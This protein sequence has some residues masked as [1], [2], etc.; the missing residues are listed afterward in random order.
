MAMTNQAAP[1]LTVFFDGACPLC[2]AEIGL[3]QKCAGAERVAFVDVSAAPDAPVAPG[4]SRGDAMKRF[5]VM[6]P[7]GRIQSG[8]RA[9][10]DLWAILPGWARLGRAFQSRAAGAVLELA[11]RAFLPVRPYL[12][13]IVRARSHPVT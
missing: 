2:T 1:V 12:Q 7:D 5:H 10:A 11:Y 4:L 9:F 13:R 3:Y 6:H 8:G